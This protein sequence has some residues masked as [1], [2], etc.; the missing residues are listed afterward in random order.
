MILTKRGAKNYIITIF[1]AL[2]LLLSQF[3]HIH[4]A[5]DFNINSTFNIYL[6]ELDDDFVR[7]EEILEIRSNNSKYYIPQNSEQTIV[8]KKDEMVRDTLKVTNEYGREKNYKLEESDDNFQI[9][10]T[11]ESNITAENPFFTKIE[12]KTK[13][14]VNQNGN[15]TNLYLPGLHKDV[16][17][18][19]IDSSHGLKTTYGYSFTY[20]VPIDSPQPSYMSPK[21][22]LTDTTRNHTTYTFS[23]ENR[24]GNTGWIQLGEEQFYHFKISQTIP[25]TDFLTPERLSKYTN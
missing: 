13:E 10:I 17:F 2:F 18:E 12:Y 24:I 16:Q 3:T 21:T 25:K 22:I 8:T 5:P 23:Q 19:N 4:G 20:H 1:I 6:E 15:I 7:V 14:F 11:N 9:I